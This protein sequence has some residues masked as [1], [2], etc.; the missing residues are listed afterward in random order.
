M[1]NKQIDILDI[2]LVL[3]KHKKFIFFMLLIVSAIS[4]IYVV[5]VPKLWTST[6]TILP[7]SEQN[8]SFNIGNSSFLGLS[9]TILGNSFQK[10]AEELVTIMKSRSFSEDVIHKYNLIKYFKIK[11]ADSLVAMD[12]ALIKLREK[13]RNI[14]I[15]EDTGLII[16]S[17]ITKDKFLSA[18]I[19]NYYA[20]KLEKH[21]LENRFSKGK[22][23]RI[24][25]R[26]RLD[27]VKSELDSLSLEI[28]NFK[29]EYNTIDLE[30]QSHAMITLYSDLIAKKMETEIELDY[31]SQFLSTESPKYKGLLNRNNAINQKIKEIESSDQQ[32]RIKFALNLE[33]IPDLQLRFSKLLIALEI[34][35]KL[36]TY[37]YPEYEEA[38]IE[39]VKDL[40]T[41]EIIDKA[42]PAGLRSY[43]KRARMCVTN[44]VVTFILSIFL[45][46]AIEYFQ[47]N[48]DRFSLLMKHLFNK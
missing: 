24:F 23:K 28:S 14:N 46:F 1:E 15:D 26:K 8:S 38:K 31:S 34:Q 37:L 19:S 27:E 5:I 30:V 44:F 10:D 36:Y 6:T 32:N 2:L 25:I 11:N 18:D 7:A 39:E 42:V 43:P 29:K 3:A 4:V 9:S 22:I 40:P 17:I 45:S 41:I 47:N 16:I 21:N 12:R 33:E 20:K 13:I 48:K 35:K